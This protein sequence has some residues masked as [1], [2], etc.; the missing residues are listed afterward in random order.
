MPSTEPIEPT[1]S[2]RNAVRLAR[3]NAINHEESSL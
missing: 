1:A 2:G 3:H